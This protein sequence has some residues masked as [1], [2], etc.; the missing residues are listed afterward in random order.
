MFDQKNASDQFFLTILRNHKCLKKEEKRLI[1]KRKIGKRKA[2]ASAGP[3]F[4]YRLNFI[5]RHS[6][7]RFKTSVIYHLPAP[8]QQT[9]VKL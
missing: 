8:I 6:S 7:S 1:R 5:E 4:Y 9:L 3:D 2:S